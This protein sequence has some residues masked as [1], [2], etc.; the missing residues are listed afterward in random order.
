LFIFSIHIIVIAKPAGLK[1]PLHRRFLDFGIASS[2][3]SSQ[4]PS[5]SSRAQRSDLLSN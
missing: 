1:Q 3:H 4:R 2:L 5:P